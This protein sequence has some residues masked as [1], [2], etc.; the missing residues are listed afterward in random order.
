LPNL[1]DIQGDE[2]EGFY[3]YAHEAEIFGKEKDNLLIDGCLVNNLTPKNQNENFEK[4]R[5]VVFILT[6]QALPTPD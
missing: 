4:Q 1:L 5:N 3:F 2:K 6:I